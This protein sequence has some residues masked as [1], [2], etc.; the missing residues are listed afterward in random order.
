MLNIDRLIPIIATF[1]GLK[2]ISAV[3]LRSFIS[4]AVYQCSIYSQKVVALP[5]CCGQSEAGAP[6]PENPVQFRRPAQGQS[7]VPF[8]NPPRRRTALCPEMSVAPAAVHN[9]SPADWRVD[10]YSFD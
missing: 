1:A 10:H 2:S 8:R 9:S 7:P 4:S 3:N 5:H 6:K